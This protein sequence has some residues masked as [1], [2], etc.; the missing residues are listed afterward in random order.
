MKADLI[1]HHIST[2]ITLA[3]ENRLRCGEEMSDVSKIEQGFIAIKDGKFIA[4]GQGED[5][6]NY[7]SEKTVLKSGKGFVVTPGFID[8]HTHLVH[9]GSREHELEMKLKG[10]PYLDILKQGGGILSTVKATQLATHEELYEKAKKSLD[11]ML[12][13]GVTSIEA[14]SGYGLNLETE[15]K[16]LEVAKQLNEDHPVDIK[17]TFLGAHAIPIE[18][19]ECKEDYIKKVIEM[20]PIIKEHELASYCDVFCEEGVFSIEESR[21]ILTEAKKLGFGLKIHADEI[22]PLGGATLACV[23]NCVSADH[24]MASTIED[25]K[26]LAKTKIVANLLP[27]TSFNLNKDY[28]KARL[29]IENNCG[30]ALSSDYNPGSC[31]SENLQFVMQLGCIKLRMLPSEVLT[32]VTINA[33]CCIEEQERIGSIEVGKD[34]DFVLLD[35]PN[36]D[37]LVYHFGINHVNDVYKKGKCVVQNKKIVY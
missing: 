7:I 16:Q 28:A 10:I 3:G 30:I 35:I 2:L 15:M 13:H 9:G 20:L 18:Y 27:A 37:Y 33:A 22:V 4:I 34:A 1:I 11:L 8:S 26:N 23:L 25:F 21:F 17:S 29:M 24:L 12:L 19:K 5:Y 32:A 36:L 14:K 6:K 31:P